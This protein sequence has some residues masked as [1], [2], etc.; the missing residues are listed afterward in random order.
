MSCNVSK[1]LNNIISNPGNTL[2]SGVL[3]VSSRTIKANLYF[4]LGTTCHRC[5]SICSSS[6]RASQKKD[7][8][9]RP[10]TRKHNDCREI[11]S[12]SS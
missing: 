1:R 10:Q 8:T 9:F 5:N 2:I 7:Y 4:K 11:G 6:R 3:R 12:E